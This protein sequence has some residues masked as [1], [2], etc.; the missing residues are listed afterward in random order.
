MGRAWLRMVQRT[1]DGHWEIGD[2]GDAEDIGT[3][4]SPVCAHPTHTRRGVGGHAVCAD[5]SQCTCP[6]TRIPL[7]SHMTIHT[8]TH[9]AVSHGW[10]GWYGASSSMLP[11]NSGRSVCPSIC[12]IARFS[13]VWYQ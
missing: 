9:I 7:I 5:V 10:S 6:H 11:T 1:K 2:V 8:I 4:P 3:A 12:W 13:P